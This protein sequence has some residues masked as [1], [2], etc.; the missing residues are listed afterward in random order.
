MFVFSRV[1]VGL[2]RQKKKLKRFFCTC[3]SILDFNVH[4]VNQAAEIDPPRYPVRCHSVWGDADGLFASK[5]A[6]TL[7][8]RSPVGAGLLAKTDLKAL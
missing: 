8:M 6:P 3:K 2:A 7:E 4:I 1:V 5:P